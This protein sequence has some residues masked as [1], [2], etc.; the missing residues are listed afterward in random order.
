M[1]KNPILK[2]IRQTREKMAA[3]AGYD[4]KRLFA[5]IR[6]R[7]AAAAARGVVFIPEP[8]GVVN[9]N[10]GSESAAADGVLL[11]R[12]GVVGACADAAR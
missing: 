9:F 5:M 10:T 3:E 7:Q 11:D 4:P 6:E 1:K 2:E 8:N 12:G